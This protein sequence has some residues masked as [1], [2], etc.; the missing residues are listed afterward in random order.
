MSV[1][2]CELRPTTIWKF[3]CEF[4]DC[5]VLRGSIEMP[6]VPKNMLCKNERRS[7]TDDYVKI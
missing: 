5:L 2:C 1:L 7:Q 6:F 4:F 3:I